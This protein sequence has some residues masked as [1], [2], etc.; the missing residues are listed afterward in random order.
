MLS[1]NP[2]YEGNNLEKAQEKPG[3]GRDNGEG[4]KDPDEVIKKFAEEFSSF[5]DTKN[6]SKMTPHLCR[7]ECKHYDSAGDQKRSEF[8]EFYWKSKESRIERGSVCG[9]FERKNPN[10]LEEVI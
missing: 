3:N 2:G 5:G 1:E 7:K 4:V 10:L 6:L 9:N 8:R